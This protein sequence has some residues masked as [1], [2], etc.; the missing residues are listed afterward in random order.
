MPDTTNTTLQPVNEPLRKG[1]AVASL[2]AIAKDPH[3]P[4]SGIAQSESITALGLA[5]PKPVVDDKPR[6]S[7]HESESMTALIA[8]AQRMQVLTDLN[9]ATNKLRGGK[10]KIDAPDVSPNAQLL[11]VQHEATS[12]LIDLSQGNIITAQRRGT[13]PAKP[14]KAKDLEASLRKTFRE[15][16]INAEVFATPQ[17]IWLSN[18]SIEAVGSWMKQREGLDK[19]LE[20][21]AGKNDTPMLGSAE[22]FALVFDRNARAQERNR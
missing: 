7:I 20:A 3:Q 16:G 6:E 9:K 19:S 5:R 22:R 13:F 12:E 17:G 14:M 10:F 21:S 2:M 1:D 4:I 8:M 18:G 11:S 15:L